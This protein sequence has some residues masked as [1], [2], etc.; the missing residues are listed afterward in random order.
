MDQVIAYSEGNEALPMNPFFLS[1]DD[2]HR[3]MYEI[4]APM[5]KKL[6]VPAT[7]FLVT[8]CLD[9]RFLIYPHRKSYLCDV[10]EK[11]SLSNHDYDYLKGAGIHADN[12]KSQL[13]DIIRKI[14]VNNHE[15]RNKIDAIADILNVS[16]DE[17][18]STHQPYLTSDQCHG[19]I[20]QGFDIGSHGLDHS[21]LSSL[22]AAERSRQVLESTH[23]LVNNFGI[24]NVGFAFPNGAYAADEPWMGELIEGD[25][26]LKLFFTTAK[27]KRNAYP[28]INRLNMDVSIRKNKNYLSDGFD[29]LAMSSLLL[30]CI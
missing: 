9:N 2:G 25:K 11:N 1:F 23:M 17:V 16:W 12:G 21:K 30:D 28:C 4:V 26:Y 13:V 24:K 20:R 5:L 29:V 19:L 6:G 3:E 27:M 14:N 8:D 22:V 18:L 15:G 7:F 10:I